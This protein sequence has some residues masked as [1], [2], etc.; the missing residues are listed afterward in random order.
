MKI[1]KTK[2]PEKIKGN[3]VSRPSGNNPFFLMQVEEVQGCE[4]V[5]DTA[6]FFAQY[7][8]SEQET[9]LTELEE[10]EKL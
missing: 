10:T 5:E 3:I 7:D 2:S 9:E 4:L 6:A 1:I 8:L